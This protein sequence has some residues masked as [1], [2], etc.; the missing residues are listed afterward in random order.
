MALDKK[1]SPLR[2]CEEPFSLEHGA[3]RFFIC[4]IRAPVE[5]GNQGAMG[6]GEGRRIAEHAFGQVGPA[7]MHVDARQSDLQPGVAV[8]RAGDC[9]SG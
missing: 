3:G 7:G 6:R 9:G 5:G 8:T 1:L 2:K 4:F